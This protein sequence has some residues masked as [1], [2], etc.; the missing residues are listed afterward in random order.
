[1]KGQLTLTHGL[2]DLTGMAIVTGLT[3]LINTVIMIYQLTIAKCTIFSNKLGWPFHQ[4]MTA[5]HW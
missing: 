4:I 2:K 5:G 3:R 1:M